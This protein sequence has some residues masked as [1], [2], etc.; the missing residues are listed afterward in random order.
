MISAELRARL[1]GLRLKTRMN[2]GGQGIG[3]HASRSRGAGLEFAQYRA[4]EPGDEPRSID[5]KLYARSDRY[6]VRDATRDTPLQVWLLID[7]SAS[8]AQHDGARPGY[9]RLDAARELA[10]GII[11]IGLQYGD[12]FGLVAVGARGI[13]AGAPAG[14][15]LRHRDR[16]QVVL[17]EL[18]ASG[19]SPVADALR[20]LWE[21]IPAQALV[22]VLSD[23]FD[24]TLVGLVEQ[25]ARARREVISI[26][27]LTAEER[28][29]P[30]VGSTPFRDPETGIERVVD[31]AAARDDFLARFGAVRQTLAQ[32]YAASGIRHVEHVLDEPLDRPLR[33]LFSPRGARA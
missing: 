12:A 10:A 11:E 18:V 4:Y 20:P 30:F 25:L 7:T 32:R 6:F 31:A 17:H 2:P 26:Q 1:R 5:W 24:A 14:S 22:V 13:V 16:L 19:S 3:Q 29:F 15:T 28:D 27:L 33:R 9:T 8:M 21:R 23:G